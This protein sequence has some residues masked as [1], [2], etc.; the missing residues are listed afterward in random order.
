MLAVVQHSQ[1][2]SDESA[3]KAILSK[4]VLDGKPV[5]ENLTPTNMYILSQE[6]PGLPSPPFLRLDYIRLDLY[7]TNADTNNSSC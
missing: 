3:A 1:L 2:V 5:G 4:K 6:H 7:N